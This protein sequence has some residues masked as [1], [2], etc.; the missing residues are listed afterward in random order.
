MMAKLNE[1]PK[2][3]PFK[4]PDNYFE[5][6]NN[7]ILSATSEAKPAENNIRFLQKF[8]S[9][10]AFAASITG[11][12]ILSYTVINL[13]SPSSNKTEISDLSLFEDNSLILENIDIITLEENV[14]SNAIYSEIHELSSSEIIDY[15]LNENIEISEI[16]E[17]L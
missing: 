10:L 4:V 7:K 13:L 5:E 15:L 3:N 9:K 8:R 14:S 6:L 16:Y 2:K 11:L 1:I 17:K 12:I